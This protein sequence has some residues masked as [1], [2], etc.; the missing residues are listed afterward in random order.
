MP[1]PLSSN[2]GLGMKVAVLPLRRATLRTTYLYHW[3]LSAI[4]TSGP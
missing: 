1:L 3:R 2:T 4:C